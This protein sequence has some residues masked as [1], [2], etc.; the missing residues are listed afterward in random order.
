M[1]YNVIMLHKLLSVMPWVAATSGIHSFRP[2][3]LLWGGLFF[4]LLSV[5]SLG[6]SGCQQKAATV[7]QASVS[8]TLHPPT[9]T[10]TACAVTVRAIST[11]A[12]VGIIIDGTP[13]GR[14]PRNLEIP[15]GQHT[16]RLEEPGYSPATILVDARCGQAVQIAESLRDSA[17]PEVSLQ[18]LPA[19]VAPEDGL[20]IIAEARDNA[21][22]A[23][24]ALF[25]D[26]RLVY[27]VN[28]NTLRHNLDT[29]RLSPGSHRIAVEA[30]DGEGNAGRALGYFELLAPTAAA[31]VESPSSTP[32]RTA[33]EIAS[34][35]TSPTANPTAS[36]TP[37]PSVE[38][39]WAERTISTYAYEQALY[40]DPNKAGHPYP[41]L[42]RDRVGP[43]EPHS[44]E[45]VL[46]RNEYL[47]L[48][49]LP[50]LGG[51]IYQCRFLPTGQD[52]LYNNSVIKPTHW[53]PEDQGWW[54]AVGG[55]EFCLPV[56]E[57]GY[58][59]AEPW[60]VEVERHA[61]GAATLVLSILE[62]SR[63]IEARV[64]VTLRPAEAAFTIDS[65]LTNASSQPQSL[66]Y[67]INA[68]LSPGSPSVQPSLRFDYPASEV[69]IHSRGDRGL[70]EAGQRM[71]WPIY[72]GRNLSRYETWRDWLGLFAPEL[73]VPFT[74]VYDEAT[75]IGMLRAFPPEIARGVKLFGFG[76]GFGDAGA[77]TD[78]GSQYVEMWGGLTPTFW[79]DAILA[80]Q[81]DVG[82]VETWYPVVGCGPIS[83][84][85]EQ[86]AL[87]VAQRD[88]YL[89]ICVYAPRDRAWELEVRGDDQVLLRE[90][91]EVRPGKP[92]CTRGPLAGNLHAAVGVR[93]LDASGRSILSFGAAGG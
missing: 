66:Q 52:L 33:T 6:F 12:E 39:S 63:E 7:A 83:A 67:W 48:T 32:T 70:P 47:E 58:V 41:L 16:L 79:D 61:D 49:I 8:P 69:I 30:R 92:Y 93:I 5:L 37:Y 10:P 45:V 14:T 76:L 21:S 84:A 65:T 81:E 15:P 46:L 29:R 77:Y 50:E 35:I 85:N 72:G 87:A 68:M 24:M 23:Q 17:P 19:G 54:L 74:V 9:A 71:A 31:I 64:A 1:H 56:N 22:V 40:T 36:P 28:G 89:E 20:K 27:R 59:T 38:V 44:Y 88:G 42:H 25:L 86:A 3:A 13:S 4:A 78:D 57:H 43:A 2:S 75:Q 51:R 62:K 60:D 53:G 73:D 80:P 34:P 91:F 82:W 55:I 11:P 26:D 90:P 18:P